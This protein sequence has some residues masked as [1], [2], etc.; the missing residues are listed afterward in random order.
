MVRAVIDLIGDRS[1]RELMGRASRRRALSV[2]WARVAERQLDV[3]RD[4]YA[5]PRAVRR[6]VEE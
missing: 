3:Y 2:D 6:A 5:Q 1:R 4:A